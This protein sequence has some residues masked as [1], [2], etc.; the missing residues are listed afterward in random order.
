MKIAVLT[1]DEKTISAHFGRAKTC[2]VFET[3]GEQIV[4][5][6]ARAMPAHGHHDHGHHHHDHSHDHIQIQEHKHDDHSHHGG[7]GRFGQKFAAMQDC[8]V[9]LTRG[10]GYPAYD[11]L[12]QAGLRAIT[13]DIKDVETA[14]TAVI[15]NT[16]VDNPK[17]RHS[18]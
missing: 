4:S 14:V 9:V 12:T 2:L 8:Q 11:K 16:I 13:T 15:N 18:H 5:R 7:H 6:E 1:D 10:M 17:R 3:D